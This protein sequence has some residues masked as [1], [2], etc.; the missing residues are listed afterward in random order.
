MAP[1]PTPLR[2][3]ARST[4]ELG[5]HVRRGGDEAGV[6]AHDSRA[7]DS[8]RR[9]VTHTASDAPD[10]GSTPTGSGSARSFSI[11]RQL[12]PFDDRQQR[13][14]PLRRQRHDRLL[15]RRGDGARVGLRPLK[16]RPQLT[17]QRPLRLGGV[18]IAIAGRLVAVAA[19]VGE[20]P[21]NAGR[22]RRLVV[23]ASSRAMAS[24][25]TLPP[26]GNTPRSCR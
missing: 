26:A 19:V 1:A 16:R 13:V 18:N 24:A 7:A 20:P 23:T 9:S 25:S 22:R 5:E 12:P 11:L 15:I 17:E 14:T 4:C 2:R 8:G 6:I 10:S 21:L 3:K